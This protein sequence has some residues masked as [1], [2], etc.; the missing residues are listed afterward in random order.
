MLVDDLFEQKSLVAD[1]LKGYIADNG[2]TKSLISKKAGISR[3]TLD[4]LLDGNIDNKKSFERHMSK[5]LTALNMSP[6]KLM[7]YAHEADFVVNGSRK[8]PIGIQSYEKI[9][10]NNFVYVDK[11][12]YIYKLVHSGIPYFLSRPRRFG[13]SLLVSTLKA[14]WEGRKELFK[15]LAIE[16]LEAGNDDAWQAY[17][18]FHFDFSREGYQNE[19]TLEEV[20]DAHLV[21]WEEVYD[22]GDTNKTLAIRFQNVIKKAVLNTG[23]SC[24]VL[25]DE[26]DK[27]LLD[28]F[29]NKELVE[30]NRDVFKGFFSC[31]KSFDEYLKFVFI[32]GVTKF[33]KVSIFSDLNQLDDI[34]FDNAYSG[35]CGITEKELTDYFMPEI[36]AMAASKNLS[37]EDCMARLRDSY[38]GYSFSFDLLGVYN[39]YSLLKSFGKKQFGS[40][41]FETGTPTFLLKRVKNLNFD[42]KSFNDGN[43]FITEKNIS[44]YRADDENPIP[45]LYQ[46]GYLSILGYDEVRECYR[47]GFPNDEVR[48]GFLENLMGEYAEGVGAGSGKDILSI[49]HAIESGDLE[50]FMTSLTALFASILYTSGEV[51][52][53][54]YFQTVLYLLFTMLGQYVICEL[55]QNTGRV[56]CV[57]ETKKYVYIF[58]FKRDSSAEEA[59][60]QIE[61]MNYALPY[62]ADKRTIYKVGINFDSEKK[63]PDEWKKAE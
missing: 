26:Y 19:G 23:K 40:Y 62:A 32:T 48:Y 34:T 44:D 15:G 60:K 37:M 7:N 55:H 54:H 47:I 42:V 21:E 41:W 39:P 57:L 56:D 1:V 11:T 61:D 29:E 25:I 2:Y 35:L 43:I 24:V 9:R 4:K 38:D 49:D 6:D 50:G 45:L 31:L 5:I 52:F 36:G 10:S 22:C 16:R 28:I 46:T 18:I 8:L 30:R 27:P 3:P 13:K 53:E 63:M 33:N 58:E 12:E 51:V 17:P 20:L 14:Y 59:L